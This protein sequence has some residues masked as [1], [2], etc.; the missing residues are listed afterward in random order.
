MSRSRDDRLSGIEVRQ[1][2]VLVAI[3][4]HGGLTA[5]ARA[6]G[7]AQSTASEAVAALERA[8]G[9]PTVRR[10]RRRG[11]T[12]LTSAGAALLPYARDVL[13]R[14]EAAH[15]AVAEVAAEARGNIAIAS[16]ESIG[17]YFLPRVLPAVRARWPNTRFAVSIALCHDVR[18]A[19]ETGEA[20]LGLFL[21]DPSP[22][23]PADALPER[24]VL[25]ED[26]IM[27]FFAQPAHPLLGRGAA[28]VARERLA[29]FPL[30][31]SDGAGDLQA[32]I[33]RYFGADGMPGPELEVAGT[34]D[35]VK[36]GVSGNPRAIGFLADYTVRAELD[37]RQ[38]VVLP[39]RPAPPRKQ[40]QALLG[41]TAAHHPAVADLL[42]ELA[43]LL[44]TSPKHP[45][46]ALSR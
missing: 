41:P 24:R 9:T 42:D 31:V 43:E 37:Q 46:I 38:V 6:L 17:T 27:T 30:F 28:P 32:L 12:P 19:V 36:R 13:A 16:N 34:V 26:V 8:V 1:L 29:E 2:R 14:I 3:H 25:G 7:L 4:D 5:A 11:E 20:D 15:V 33:R 44:T 22:D 23:R 45:A 39:L 18:H 40:V 35:G 10:Q 21:G